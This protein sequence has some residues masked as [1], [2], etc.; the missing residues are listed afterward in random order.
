MRQV[1][2]ALIL[3]AA[4]A[5]AAGA[6]AQGEKTVKDWTGVCD[7]LAA[8]AAFGFSPEEFDVSSFIEIK[9]AAGPD[10]APGVTIVYDAD[11]AAAGGAWTLALD[12]KPIAGIGP[13][14][15]KGGAAGARARLSGAQ[16]TAL[17]AALRNGQNLDIRQ[18]G[19]TL[20]SLSLAGS[21]A[22]LL[23]VDDQQGRVGTVTALARPGSKPASSVPPRPAAPV[24]GAPPPAGQAGLP[25][26]PP[27]TLVTAIDDCE[28]DDVAKD[29]DPLVARLAPGVILWAPLCS[30][31]AYNELNVFFLIDEKGRAPRRISLPEPPGASSASDDEQMNMS[32]DPNTGELSSFAKGR[33]IGD[34]GSAE[35]WVWDGKALQLLTETEMPDCRGLPQDDWPS[36]YVAR[37]R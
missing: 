3:T 10:A 15:A 5:A 26:P 2:A 23:W 11:D 34:C 16:A 29:T 32:F 18:G 1:L 35:T 27:L 7:N 17:I 30:L 36:R 37:A 20:T 14:T 12:G 24:L 21:A 13:L 19:K 33:G 6:D 9:R 4:M 25:K 31:G 22:T 28:A 8:C